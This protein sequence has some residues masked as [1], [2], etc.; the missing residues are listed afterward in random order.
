V[1]E[2]QRTQRTQRVL[3]VV[4]AW[5]EES[6]VADT[7]HEI[8]S[9]VPH[10][11][12][13]V[14]DDGSTDRTAHRARHAGADVIELSYNL[15]VGGAMRAGFRYAERHNYDTVIQVDADGQHDPQ[16]LPALLEKLA[17]GYDV[18][19]GARFAER[20]EYKVRGPR[21]WAM[22]LIAKVLSR[23]TGTRLTDATS[24]FKA[25]GSRA[26]A[27]F[28]D[29]YPAEYLGDTIEALVIAARTGCRVAQVPVHMRCRRGGV[30]SHSPVKSAVY[31]FRAM[32]ALAMALV[33]RYPQRVPAIGE[34]SPR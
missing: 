25:S 19:I 28:A 34:R 3:V 33:R 2:A 1:P 22:V 15:G 27:L 20:G 17:E 9:A 4:P 6:C 14:V 18:V 24:G 12:I 30:P 32:L 26:I 10:A 16:E 5:N 31:L 11:D 13:I 23:I 21:K 29:H 8:R 7:I